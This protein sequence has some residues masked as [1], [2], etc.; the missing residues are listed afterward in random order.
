MESHSEPLFRFDVTGQRVDEEC[1]N[2]RFQSNVLLH[3]RLR[4]TVTQ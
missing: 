4:H 3:K 2:R 1:E